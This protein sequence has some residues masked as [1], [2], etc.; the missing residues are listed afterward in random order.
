MCNKI[1]SFNEILE[2]QKKVM[3]TFTFCHNAINVT[4]SPWSTTITSIF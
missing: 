4:L 3:E 2:Q 1:E